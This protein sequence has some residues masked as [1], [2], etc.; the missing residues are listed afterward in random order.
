[1][2]SSAEPIVITSRHALGKDIVKQRITERFEA[3]K[4]KVR[5]GV[6]G[7]HAE[8]HWDGDVAHGSAKALGQTAT[9]S[10][11]VTDEDLTITIQLPLLLLPFRS[12]IVALIE[13]Q[14]DVAKPHLAG[15][16]R[17]SD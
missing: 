7:G 11:V 5:I 2:P 4:D 12:A 15:E 1:M 8:M 10:I 14:E 6:F 13:A 16:L 3:M 9:G 17:A